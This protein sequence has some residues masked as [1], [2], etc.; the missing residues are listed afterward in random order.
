MPNITFAFVVSCMLVTSLYM[1]QTAKT[2]IPI[3]FNYAHAKQATIA[4]QALGSENEYARGALQ[5]VYG[6]AA[7]GFSAQPVPESVDDLFSLFNFLKKTFF[8]DGDD[9]E[10]LYLIGL[11][12]APKNEGLRE[13]FDA[14]KKAK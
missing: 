11:A 10:I 9:G 6:D 12:D 1:H 13:L 7:E 8:N 2:K 5:R 14:L 4:L 3:K